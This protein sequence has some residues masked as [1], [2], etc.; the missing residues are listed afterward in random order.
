MSFFFVLLFFR[1]PPPAD[2]LLLLCPPPPRFFGGFVSSSLLLLL[3]FLPHLLSFLVCLFFLSLSL[4][5]CF[6]FLAGAAT[7]RI[8]VAT[9]VFVLSRQTRV[10]HD[11]SVLAET[12][13]LSRQN[14]D[15]CVCHNKSKV[16]LLQQ[17]D[18]IMFVMTKIC[19][20]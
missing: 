14:Y 4:S 17:N 12:K 13:L 5:P 1:L 15:K 20:S 11:K 10:C 8:F 2:S 6:V 7:S 3:F 18:T 19:L 16:S 9:K